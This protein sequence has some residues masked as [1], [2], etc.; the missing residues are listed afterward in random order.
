MFLSRTLAS[1]ATAGVCLLATSSLLTGCAGVTKSTPTSASAVAVSGNWQV[2]ATGAS[3]S[4]PLPMLSGEL[5][6]SS[7]AV[8]GILHAN[9]ANACVKASSSF[10]VTGSADANNLLTLTGPVGG[11]T[12]TLTG[13]L[14]SDGKS[15]TN[16]TYSVNGG[17]CSQTSLHANAQ[18]YAD[19]TGT[20]LGKFYDS[21]SATT[22]IFQM[23]A[24][25]TQSPASDTDGNFTATGQMTMG[26]NPC[27]SVPTA[28]TSAQVTGGNFT[29]TY[30]DSK[31]GNSVTASGT[32]SPDGTTLT[33]TSWTS[34]G[35][36]GTFSGTG[37]M[38]K[39]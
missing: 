37:T 14:A 6:G 1:C 22:P 32:F 12:L 7:A 15:L 27:Y 29:M 17:T 19:I 3:T 4:T 36:C 26:Q 11:G 33:V 5:S 25:L 34:T 16:A 21:D 18:Q 30:T 38:A 9:T 24:N 39:Q 35:T 31:I 2:A 23:T 28:L 8:H 13:T 10:V 20:Y